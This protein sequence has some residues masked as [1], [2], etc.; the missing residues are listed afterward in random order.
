MPE[1]TNT[2]QKKKFHI[3]KLTIA[4]VV[5][6]IL[7]I[8]ASV[9]FFMKYQETQ[10]TEASNNAKIVEKVATTVQLPNET[11]VLVTVAD[12]TKLAN[13]QLAS[14]VENDDVMLIF[15]KERRL[16]IYRPSVDKV[17]D[18]LTFSA[19]EQLPTTSKKK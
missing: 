17:A 10:N 9:Y 8:A 7:A 6:C 4:L 19:N 15:A 5:V 3:S 14:K 12:K 16:V 2:S 11:P 18:I 13:K 1:D